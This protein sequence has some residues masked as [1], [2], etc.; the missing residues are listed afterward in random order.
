MYEEL[1]EAGGMMRYGIPS[2]RLPRE[3]LAG[4]VDDIRALGVEIICNTRVGR[5]ISFGEINEDFDYIYLAPGAHKSQPMGVEGEEAESVYGGVE[6][7]RDFNLNEDAWIRGDKS[8]GSRVAVIGGGN[9]AIDAARVAIRLGTDVTILYRRTREDMPA[10]EEEIAAAEHEGITIEY[11]VAPTKVLS[12]GGKV[13]GIA[14]ERMQPGDFD[15]SG[16]RRPVP[17]AGSE[18]TLSVDAVISAIGQQ[19]DVD[20]IPG[21]TRRFH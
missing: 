11:F 16:R 4:E 2:Y 7:L 20:F 1:P 10:A 9:S 19:P 6:F 8:L 3:I 12:E 13:T 14:C 5:E 21:N 18:F 15:R 17:I